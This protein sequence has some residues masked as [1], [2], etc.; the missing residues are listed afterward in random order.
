MRAKQQE[1]RI[2]NEMIV[3]AARANA[4]K[5]IMEANALQSMYGIPGFVDIEKAKAI[6]TNQKIFYGE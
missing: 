1:Q 6:S 2:Q 3:E 4:E 5:I